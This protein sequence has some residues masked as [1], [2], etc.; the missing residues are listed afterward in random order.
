[1]VRCVHQMRVTVEGKAE[2]SNMI[3]NLG[4]GSG[5]T[6]RGGNWK[7]MSAGWCQ[8]R[9]PRICLGSVS[10]GHYRHVRPAGSRLQVVTWLRLSWYPAFPIEAIRPFCPCGFYLSVCLSVYLSVWLSVS[11]PSIHPYI[12]PSI[13]LS[14]RPSV[15]C[16]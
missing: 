12:H 15:W 9:L 11:H 1:M 2:N 5:E 16:G 7:R 10:R 4:K 3:R 13:H 14:I 8:T 6:D